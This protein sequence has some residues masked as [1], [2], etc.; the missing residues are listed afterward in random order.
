MV[1]AALLEYEPDLFERHNVDVVFSYHHFTHAGQRAETFEHFRAQLLVPHLHRKADELFFEKGIR[2]L[3]YTLWIE[4]DKRLKVEL[5]GT[6]LYGIGEDG[7]DEILVADF[8]HLN[9]LVL[10]LCWVWKT[11]GRMSLD[12][13]LLHG[14]CEWGPVDRSSPGLDRGLHFPLLIKRWDVEIHLKIKR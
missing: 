1:D 2:L 10:P 6:L 3:Y 4:E 12:N 5:A 11:R 7:D 14:V 13:L 8:G 9:N